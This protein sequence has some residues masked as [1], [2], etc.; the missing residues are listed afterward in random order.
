MSGTSIKVGVRVRVQI[1]AEGKVEWTGDGDLVDVKIAGRRIEYI[2]V[3]YVSVIKEP[4]QVGDTVKTV[5]D[6]TNLPVGALV[7]KLGGVTRKTGPDSWELL[8]CV[9]V[10]TDTAVRTGYTGGTVIYLPEAK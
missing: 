7:L 9:E 6:F 3:E 10:Y 1:D 8:S 5:E 2:P 4:A